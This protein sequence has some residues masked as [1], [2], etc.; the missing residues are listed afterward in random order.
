[1]DKTA[2]YR[3]IWRWHFYAGLFVIPFIL[4]L[5]VTGS[6]YL[7]KPQIDRWQESDWRGLSLQAAVSPDQQLAAALAANPGATFHNYRLPEYPDDNALIHIGLADGKSM[8]DIYVSPQGKVLAS[9]DPESRISAVVARIHGSLLIGKMGNYLVE[10]AASWAIVMILSGLY[11][12]WPRGQML[13]G[14]LWP[15]RGLG[16][17]G[18]WR[19]I[20]AVTGFWISGLALI[21]LAS[22]LPWTDVWASGFQMVRT[23]MAWTYEQPQDWKGGGQKH[24][25]HMEHDHAAM[26]A[27]QS[28]IAASAS[29]VTLANLV[30][31]AEAEAM[32]FPAIIIPPGAPMP[33]GPPNGDDW[34]L[35]SQTQNRPLIRT[36]TYDAITG[37]ETSRSG[38]ADKHVIDRVIGYGI[39]W[40]EGQL[41]GW[42]NQLVGVLTAF[43]LILLVVS[44]A[45][46]WWKRRPKDQP[47]YRINAPSGPAKTKNVFFIAGIMALLLPMVALSL[48][49]ILPL[50]WLLSRSFR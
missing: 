2:L 10:L 12:W 15:R 31:K 46:M 36:V 34:K 14:I 48:L 25:E 23:Q 20:H 50:D 26:M 18:F 4:I 40:H 37:T 44:G 27:T 6:I 8:R 45:N 41:L 28:E 35:T 43:A 7:F 11:L 22:G 21:T 3:T 5:S 38:F 32:P 42:F 24:G 17:R 47:W 39:A 49:I 13:A 33:F 1:M 16:Q 9:I 30:T 19:D 29:K